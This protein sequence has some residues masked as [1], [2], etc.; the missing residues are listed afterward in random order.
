M[1]KS[2]N[3]LKSIVIL[4]IPLMVL[5]FTDVYGQKKAVNKVSED[6]TIKDTKNLSATTLR[7]QGKAKVT[8][9]KPALEKIDMTLKT[10][11]VD[12]V[13]IDA[14]SNGNTDGLLKEL[15]TIGLKDAKVY[16]KKINGLIPV[17]SIQSLEKMENL[18][19]AFPVYKPVLNSGPALTNGDT[20]L[21]SYVS[22][23]A[24]GLDG[25]GIKIGVLSD[26]YN[27]LLGAEAGVANDELPG[28]ANPNGYTS[29][30][31][32]LEDIEDGSDEGRAMCEIIHDIAPAAEMAFNTAYSG[33]AGFALGILNLADAG[34]D[35]ITDDV[36]YLNEPFFQDGII[37]QAVDEV[38]KKGGVAYYTSAG[39]YD[40]DSY[41]SVFRDGGIHHI[42][43]PYDGFELGQYVMHDFDPGPG[44]DLF[45]EIVFAPGDD[46]TCSFQWDDPFASACEDCPGAASDLDIFLAL[47]PDTA[48]VL[49][50]SINFN[51][52]GD[53]VELLGANY[54]GDDTLVAYI[55]FGKWIDAPG[56]NPNPGFVKYI[57]FGTALPGEYVTNS[58]TTMGHSNSRYGISVGA[59]AWFYTPAYGTD[60]PEINYFSSAGGIPI[61]F[62]TKG[63]KLRRPEIRIHPLFTAT[64]GGNTSFFGQMLNDGDDF[65]NFFGTSAAAPHAAAVAAQLHQMADGRLKPHHINHILSYT[66][67]DMDDPFTS[68]FD[69]GYDRKTG[70]G[71]IQAD[72]AAEAVLRRVGIYKLIPYAE[73]SEK[74]DSTRRWR[75]NNPNPFDVEVSWEVLYSCQKGSFIAKP[76]DNYLETASLEYYN[77]LLTSYKDHHGRTKRCM[78]YSPG[79]VCSSFKTAITASADIIEPPTVILGVYPNPFKSYITLELFSG[80]ENEYNI[81]IYTMQGAEVFSS[82]INPGIDYSTTS[83]N[84]ADLKDGLYIMKI[85]TSDG[86]LCDTYKLMKQ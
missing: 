38:V 39:N 61:L 63:R 57:N 1:K 51:I 33:T 24:R 34:C 73:C 42:I 35:I 25:T 40:R 69:R 80:K 52:D 44:V 62:D 29:E 9:T 55:A 81:K 76:G 15:K 3:L 6:L 45:Q 60:P 83:I 21:R 58:P 26:S 2:T 68:W 48:D 64:D 19:Y 75:I 4:L 11:D 82:N 17:E 22:R 67:I 41:S 70:F 20:A 14:I 54:S 77:M 84:L 36:T 72:K 50:Q 18:V 65:P 59:S 30:V 78:A 71:L 86:K 47:S 23:E 32:V 74:P 53:P 13:L 37:A 46:F 27:S 7:S 31:E 56:D 66:T 10:A 49:L 8:S 43:N 12:M 28:T 79:E 85:Y 16:G 5:C